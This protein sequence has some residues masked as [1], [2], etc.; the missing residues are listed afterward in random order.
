MNIAKAVI[1]GISF[2]NGNFIYDGTAKSLAITGTLPTGAIVSYTGNSQTNAGAYTITANISGGANYNDQTLTAQLTIA[3]AAIMGISFANGNFIYDGTAKS[4]AIAGTLPTGATV[5]YTGNSQTNAGAYTIAANISGGTNY[6]D[7]TLTA[8]LTISKAAITGI[9]F[10]NGNFIYDGTAKSLAIAGTL[11]TGATV[12]YTGNS[13]NNAGAYTIMANIIGGTNYQDQTL[14]AQLNIA[15]AIV[16]IS[17]VAKTKTYGDNDPAFTYNGNGLVG[18]D[19]ITGVMD[20]APG[21]NVGTYTITVGSLSAGNNYSIV[22]TPAN[23]SVTKAV[24]TITAL[25][26]VRCVGQANPQVGLSYSG[27]RFNDS[28][29]SLGTK[30][31]TST[32]ANSGSTP[33]NYPI[34]AAGAVSANYT[35]MYVNGTL[36]VDALPNL[37]IAPS[38]A[39]TLAKGKSMT[40]TASGGSS[41]SWSN[42]Q[43]VVSGQNSAILTVRPSAT[44]TYT[45]MASNANG[46][47]TTATYTVVVEED[48][49][50]LSSNNLLTPNGDGQ[51]DVWKVDNIDMYPQATV[52]IFDRAG[53]I[54][55]TRKAYDNS[56]DGTYN[57][58]PLAEGTYY[59][60]IDLNDKRLL[61][62]YITMVRD[63]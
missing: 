59:Y 63:R 42:A 49:A 8:Q 45:V 23:L 61:K 25:N 58:Q 44:T 60:V 27:F 43:G 34:L 3:K 46:C 5:G 39:G 54:L 20:R 11:P 33:G 40:L 15:K 6:Q 22:Y 16:N 21:E 55:Y 51:N 2:A 35:F 26:G 50:V 56:W 19:G 10:A 17:A 29:A 14:T 32:A 37:T 47:S 31:T 12:S 18:T 30:P 38:I 13:Q 57:G 36:R 7:Q 62:G 48:L 41:Y 24:L 53:R 9:S 28:E 4:L 1:T 52:K